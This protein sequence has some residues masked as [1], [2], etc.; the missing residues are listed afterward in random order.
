VGFVIFPNKVP[1][2]YAK[3]A[4][5]PPRISSSPAAQTPRT[6]VVEDFRAFDLLRDLL[7]ELAD[8]ELP[9]SESNVAGLGGLRCS[10]PATQTSW[11]TR[12]RLP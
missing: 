8:T 12:V 4:V 11:Q 3:S 2:F 7:R 5:R 1:V 6:L 9:K 10:Q